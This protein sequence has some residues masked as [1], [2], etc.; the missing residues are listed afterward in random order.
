MKSCRIADDVMTLYTLFTIR[1]S[2][3]ANYPFSFSFLFCI[4]LVAVFD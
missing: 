2:Q 1:I 3:E 4:S